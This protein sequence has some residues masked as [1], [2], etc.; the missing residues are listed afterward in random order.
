[1]EYLIEKWPELLLIVI[2]L[3]FFLRAIVTNIVF[4]FI[5]FLSI[6]ILSLLAISFRSAEKLVNWANNKISLE[7]MREKGE[8]FGSLIRNIQKDLMDLIPPFIPKRLLVIPLE[9]K[10]FNF[11]S[12]GYE[13]ILNGFIEV[14]GSDNKSNSRE[15]NENE[16]KNIL[17]LF[18]L[19]LKLAGFILYLLLMFVLISAPTILF[20]LLI[21]RLF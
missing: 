15:P 20:I 14:L 16:N 3:I 4:L 10:I 2:Y 18:I 11:Y 19:Y 1:M 21:I 8:N 5:S 12:S 6:F 9:E 17:S 7:D 13:N